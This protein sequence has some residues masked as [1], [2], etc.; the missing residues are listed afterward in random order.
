MWWL[1]GLA[2]PATGDFGTSDCQAYGL[3]GPAT[4]EVSR[5]HFVI[6]S[7]LGL[8]LTEFS[9][10]RLSGLW[11]WQGLPRT[12]SWNSR[13]LGLLGR[14]M[15]GSLSCSWQVE[16]DRRSVLLLF[17]L[18]TGSYTYVCEWNVLLVLELS[19]AQ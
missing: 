12:I 1:L 8:P 18:K 4:D 2:G 11:S 7:L 16:L 5:F 17:L 10:P 14:C 13:L 3:A 15:T 9:H 19:C 6:W